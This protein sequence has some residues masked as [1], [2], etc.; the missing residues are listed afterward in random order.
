[1]TSSLTA[2]VS[3]QLEGF[4]LPHENAHTFVKWFFTSD[5]LSLA[6]RLAIVS[7]TVSLLK[8]RAHKAR[9]YI[10]N[11][12]LPTSTERLRTHTM[13]AQLSLSLRTLQVA[14]ANGPW[15][16]CTWIPTS[17]DSCSNT[18]CLQT[19]PRML[20]PESRGGLATSEPGR[21]GYKTAYASEGPLSTV[22]HF[23][24]PW[25]ILNSVKI[26]DANFAARTI[27]IKIGGKKLWA[28]RCHSGFGA[29]TNNIDH[30][31]FT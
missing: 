26:T 12:E 31:R 3:D 17:R 6:F 1:M 4:G 13:S 15:L 19:T 18:A 7:L 30:F 29:D 25:P 5:I 10:Y 11:C 9:D 20:T 21:P 27:L 23:P 8:S 16:T 14:H 28:T 2:L 24:D 22:R